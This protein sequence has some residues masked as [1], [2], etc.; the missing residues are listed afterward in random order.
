MSIR[1]DERPLEALSH[2]CH[3]TRVGQ[4]PGAGD[5]GIRSE[6]RPVRGGQAR[7]GLQRH[8]KERRGVED[9]G[10][11]VGGRSGDAG[12]YGGFRRWQF[13]DIAVE[14][15]PGSESQCSAIH[16]AGGIHSDGL[17][18]YNGPLEHGERS[19]SR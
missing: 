13:A 11:G 4:R 7:T 10:Y 15:N 9:D 1:G 8:E 5:R 6:R 12:K 14:C 3:Y 16:R 19:N 17:I 2:G 18:R